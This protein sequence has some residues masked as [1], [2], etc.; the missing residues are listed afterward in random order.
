MKYFR[1]TSLADALA[2]RRDEDVTLLAGATDVYPA[3]VG[4]KAWGDPT[5]K[6]IL[7]LSALPGL[8]NIEIGENDVRLGALVTWSDLARANLP[9]QFD[10]LRA[11]ARDVGGEQIQ[12][13]ATIVGNACTA[14][15][16]GDGIPNLL[17]LDAS[18]E[19]AGSAPR[20]VSARDFF[21]GYRKID[22]RVDEIVTGIRIPRQ[23]ARSAFT[24]LG[25]RRYLV[26]SIAMVAAIIETDDHDRITAT[27]IAVGACSAVAMRLTGLEEDLIGQRLADAATRAG[28][29][30]FASLKPIDD[31][32][33]SAAYRRDVALTLVRDMLAGFAGGPTS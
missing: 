28:P 8:R 4:R 21:T 24:K 12:N 15:P 33:A 13:R 19:I 29:E 22:C 3:Y 10:G 7:D 16:A 5:H 6:D 26:I 18:F 17:A 23:Q 25:A 27:R 9:A 1:P 30:H 2:I 32:R 31:I 20:L 14:S 11:A